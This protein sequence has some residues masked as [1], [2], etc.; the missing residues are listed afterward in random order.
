MRDLI[1]PADQ[2]SAYAVQ[3][4]VAA[5]R[6]RGG[7]RPCGRK[8]GLT[9]KAVQ[10]QLGVDQ[11]DFGVLFEDMI[12]V[13]GSEIPADRVLQ[14]RVEAE[15][16]F[17]LEH[18]LVEGPLDAEQVRRATAYVVP[19]L[20]VCGSRITGWNISFADTVADNASSGA[21]VVGEDA[22][23]IDQVSTVD[24]AMSMSVDGVK[25]S[26]GTG[27]DCLGD[28]VLAV[29]WLA[30]ISRGIGAPLR[31]G[32]LVMS[33]ALGPMFPLTPGARVTATFPD[34]GTVAM[35]LGEGNTT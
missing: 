8:V 5:Q 19:A 32:E 7:A 29:A 18:D 4:L 9:S 33:G 23:R 14:P 10:A 28:P 34:L 2:E 31:A 13:G 25:V 6:T 22:F 1:G 17:M 21:V 30:Q 15:L 11:P 20:E 3:R 24:L 26:A 35:R 27:R 12:H 16:A